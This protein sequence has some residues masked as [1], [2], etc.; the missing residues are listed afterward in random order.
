MFF[1]TVWLFSTNLCLGIPW[2]LKKFKRRGDAVP[3][4]PNRK[5]FTSQL[6]IWYRIVSDLVYMEQRSRFSGLMSS[7]W[8][9]I[10]VSHRIV[11]SKTNLR[12]FFLSIIMM[13]T[14]LFYV[15]ESLTA[16]Q[17]ISSYTLSFFPRNR[18]ARVERIL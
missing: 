9:E 5:P 3:V 1:N 15:S 11:G 12:F 13:S 17:W 14:L 18:L 8:V 16:W 2:I 10:F 6:L 4:A 7:S